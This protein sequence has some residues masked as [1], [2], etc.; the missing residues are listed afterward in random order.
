MSMTAS[1]TSLQPEPPVRP[2]APLGTQ[3]VRRPLISDATGLLPYKP[4]SAGGPDSTIP[5]AA[6]SSMLL[7]STVSSSAAGP[8]G[9]RGP[10]VPA[11]GQL[12]GAV[13]ASYLEAARAS[14][15]SA[16]R[17]QQLQQQAAQAV[18]FGSV[19]PTK[20][21]PAVSSSTALSAALHAALLTGASTGDGRILGAAAAAQPQ[22]HVPPTAPRG[23]VDPA[24]AGGVAAGDVAATAAAA[25]FQRKGSAI[26]STG[27]SFTAVPGQLQN[28]SAGP[29]RGAPSRGMCSAAA[30]LLP[31]VMVMEVK[32]CC[33]GNLG[34]HAEFSCA[35]T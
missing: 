22:P 7:L 26:S 2:L 11:A 19:F 34:I 3:R 6:R 31:T 10:L 18:A 28:P 12:P 4:Y 30:R 24:A 17:Q 8:H 20:P 32:P 21:S 5:P 14:V 27:G 35:C 25:T 9:S 15:V 13:S 23:D 1:V 16:L 29:V 33:A